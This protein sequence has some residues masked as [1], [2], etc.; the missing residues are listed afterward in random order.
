MKVGVLQFFG[1]LDRSVPLASIYELALE[2]IGEAVPGIVVRGHQV[3]PDERQHQRRGERGRG[4]AHPA[5]GRRDGA[6][7]AR[8]APA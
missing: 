5:P 7:L 2:R 1:W 6:A 3:D 4:D 8:C